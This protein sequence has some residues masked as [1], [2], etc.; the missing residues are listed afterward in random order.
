MRMELLHFMILPGIFLYIFS[1]YFFSLKGRL[2][3][4]QATYL[5]PFLLAV[6]G[7]LSLIPDPLRI[8]YFPAPLLPKV[9]LMFIILSGWF[10]VGSA[11]FFTALIL[12]SKL[13]LGFHSRHEFQ[14]IH[15]PVYKSRVKITSEDILRKLLEN[16]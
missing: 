1:F 16:D 7:T 13:K 15:Q 12:Y 5:F 3:N 6:W 4:R 11:F 8:I 9:Y 14:P 2:P 10:I